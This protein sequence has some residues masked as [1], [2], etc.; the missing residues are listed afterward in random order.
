MKRYL[1][2][3]WLF[4]KRSLIDQMAYRG[5]FFLAVLGKVSRMV[6]PFIFF[7]AIFLKVPRV[8]GWN[9][10]EIAVLIATYLTLESLAV[11]T[12]H[13]NLSYYLPDSLRNGE[14]DFLLTKPV[15]TL[16]FSS[17]KA[18]DFFDLTSAITAVGAWI[19]IFKILDISINFFN[20]LPFF[21]ACFIGLAFWYGLILCLASTSFWT[22]TATG[23]G[24]FLE[25]IIRTS[26]YPA[27]V[28]HG[29]WR[30][31]VFY[32]F[33]LAFMSTLPAGLL[34]GKIQPFYLLYAFIFV[35]LALY[36]SVKFWKYAL[37]H[38]QSAA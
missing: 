36:L 30:N 3:L 17:F 15:G 23:L 18:I 27:T 2:L 26:R 34:L 37:R 6:I 32:I 38:Y 9:Y 20:F 10:Q 24:R 7:Q 14:F 28:F 25:G 13:R 22:I 21:I 31:V 29:H 1:K 35:S 12:F 33:P 8:G 11:I 4:A 5:T 16:F 19:Y